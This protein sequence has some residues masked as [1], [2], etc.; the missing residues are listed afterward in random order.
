MSLSW[1]ERKALLCSILRTEG[2]A[3][4]GLALDRILHGQDFVGKTCTL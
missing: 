4:E 1:A 3:E 2:E